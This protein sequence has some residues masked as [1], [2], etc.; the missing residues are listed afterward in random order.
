MLFLP[1]FL[2]LPPG[3]TPPAYSTG[4][5]E[6]SPVRPVAE[7]SGRQERPLGFDDAVNLVLVNS[8]ELKAAHARR[9]LREGGWVLGL[10]AYFPQFSLGASE[11]DRLSKIGSD[12][13]LK[14]YTVS[15][16]Q[17]LWDGGRTRMSRG[18][19]KAE[20]TLMSD[21]IEGLSSRLAESALGAYRQI[22]SARMIVSI[23]ESALESLREQQRILAEELSLG[24]VIP[25]EL[26]E[27]EITVKEAEL[28]LYSLRLELQE[29]EKEFAAILGLEELP[30][31]SETVDLHRSPPQAEAELI[32]RAALVR[33]ADLAALYHSVLQKQ[34]ESK[35]ASLSWIPSL[36]GSASFTVSGQR[37]P[38]S[39]YSWSLGL[40]VQ[41][42]SPWFSVSAGGNA[43]WEPPYD[44]T[45]RAQTSV[46]PLPDP[47]SALNP[48]QARLAL[49]LERE[50]LRLSR[51]RVGRSAALGLEKMILSGERKA[52]ALKALGLAEEKYRLQELLL[53]LG[54]ITRVELM[55]ERLL[56]AQK[57]AEAVEAAAAL[58]TAEWELERLLNLKPGTLGE[59]IVHQGGIR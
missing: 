9:A 55:E 49:A 59:F 36:R 21:E 44:R 24:L 54:R 43:D 26:K 37:Y 30:P 5:A 50:N 41:F 35:F 51:E 40:T 1:L 13:F 18:L 42:S 57:E 25:L 15:L 19:E 14:N 4:P 58:L 47:A 48:K 32:R 46:S 27:G 34:A 45:A 56:Y 7:A 29:L 20:I 10:R 17:L 12:S 28:E 38:L 16:D 39:R 52:S 6:Q 3:G 33:N 31:L 23:R 22:L 2:F 11:D 53:T 8:T